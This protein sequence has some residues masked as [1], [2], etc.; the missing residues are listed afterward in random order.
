MSKHSVNV[1]IPK[2]RNSRNHTKYIDRVVFALDD[3]DPKSQWAMWLIEAAAAVIWYQRFNHNRAYAV[4]EWWWPDPNGGLKFSTN[5]IPVLPIDAK[6]L[7]AIRDKTLVKYALLID[8]NNA[9]A[10]KYAD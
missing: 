6:R 10:M 8:P 1:L 7:F 3:A 5:D 4:P 9:E 2:F